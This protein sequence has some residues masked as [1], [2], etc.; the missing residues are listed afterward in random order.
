MENNRIVP[1]STFLDLLE[2]NDQIHRYVTG[3]PNIKPLE[4]DLKRPAFASLLTLHEFGLWMGNGGQVTPLH[5]DELENTMV[6]FSGAKKFTLFDPTMSRY[7]YPIYSNGLY[8]SAINLRDPQSLEKYPL[9]QHAKNVSV[10]VN[11]G[12]ILFVPAYW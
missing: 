12:D 6:V 11:A 4:K 7:L 5:F 3:V 1:F 10:I 2:Q 9:F 8:S